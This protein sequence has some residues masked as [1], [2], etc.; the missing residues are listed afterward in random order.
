M[1]KVYDCFVFYNEFD[2]LDIRLA[3]MYKHVDKFVIVEANK[4]FSSTSKSYFYLENKE[5]YAK[6][7]DKIIHVMVD[8]MPCDGNAWNNEAHQRNC[9]T[10]GLNE[11]EPEDLILI[12]DVDEI[13][14]PEAIDYARALNKDSYGFRVP[15]FNFKFNYML[16]GTREMYDVWMMGVKKAHLNQ[17][18]DVIRRKRLQLFQTPFNYEGDKFAMIEHA[19]WHFTY[20][21]ND[22]FIKNKIRNFS[23][24]ELNVPQVLDQIDVKGAMRRGV[25][26]NPFDPR[27]FV[28]VVIDDYFPKEILKYPQY[29]VKNPKRKV[30]EFLPR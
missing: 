18:V 25:G 8:D 30:M 7:A 29:I 23:H 20:L 1:S 9:I 13:F 28:P 14:R 22:E 11:A 12:S 26:F 21:G 15:Y 4:S 5:R 19:G 3:L 24:Q 6:Y 2:L 27:P 17:P 16:I 10:R